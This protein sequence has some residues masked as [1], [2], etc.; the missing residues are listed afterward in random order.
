[1][2]QYTVIYFRQNVSVGNVF[3]DQ[4]SLVRI[5]LVLLVNMKYVRTIEF[6]TLRY[7]DSTS[8]KPLV[9]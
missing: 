3:S 6:L 4:L 9:L 5:A 1:M 8:T 2:V 7:L